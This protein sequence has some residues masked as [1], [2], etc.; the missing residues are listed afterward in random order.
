MLK[1]QLAPIAINEIK[2]RIIGCGRNDVILESFSAAAGQLTD[3]SGG[4]PQLV[5]APKGMQLV[6]KRADAGSW[7]EDNP[8]SLG[9]D[10]DC[11]FPVK[12]FFKPGIPKTLGPRRYRKFW[13]CMVA[14]SF[15]C[16]TT[17]AVRGS[18]RA[19]GKKY[20]SGPWV[21]SGDAYT[22]VPECDAAKTA[23][24]IWKKAP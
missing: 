6:A 20:G 7:S 12:L 21:S 3:T 24:C 10:P 1:A 19:D 14:T 22:L 8:A 17:Y 5:G 16:G 15:T 9:A 11:I 13:K 2:F 4:S 18:A 23:A